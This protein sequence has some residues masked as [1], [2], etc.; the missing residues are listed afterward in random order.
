VFNGSTHGENSACLQEVFLR[1]MARFR[2]G[3]GGESTFFVCGYMECDRELSKIFL[4]GL[5]PVF[6][7]NIRNDAAGQWL[8]NSIKFSAD[9]AGAHRAGSDAVLTRLSEALFVETMRRYMAELPQDQTGW[10]AGA[11]DPM[12]G[13][14]L[15]HLHR[16][17]ESPWTIA[18]L[19]HEVG[20]S[21][22]VLAERFR[23]FL[24]EP[25]MTYLSRWR[26]QLGARMLTSTSYSVARISGDVGYESEPAFNRAFK[27]EFGAPPARFRTQVKLAQKRPEHRH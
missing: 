13:A 11:R 19:A 3:G 9:A 23:Y 6:K 20:A 8:E 12:V 1:G 18:E 2:R 15:A 22:S 21:R 4:G 24:G 14:A 10:L 25:P 26:L 16:A 27:R 5:P 7:V 17:P